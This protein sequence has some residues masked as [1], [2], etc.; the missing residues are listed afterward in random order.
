MTLYCS[1]SP[2]RAY[3]SRSF[4]FIFSGPKSIISPIRPPWFGY[5]PRC[6]ALSLVNF[7][8]I[9]G[10]KGQEGFGWS[11][12]TSRDFGR[13]GLVRSGQLRGQTRR[14][15]QKRQENRSRYGTHI[16]L[17]VARI[18]GVGVRGLFFNC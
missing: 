3:N 17:T 8:R 6:N 2:N 14:R 9:Q 7:V 13:G 10:Q 18:Q 16:C 5:C 12:A 4:L 11:D 1:R 15:S